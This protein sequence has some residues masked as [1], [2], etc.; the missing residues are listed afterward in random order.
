MAISAKVPCVLGLAGNLVPHSVGRSGTAS[1]SGKTIGLGRTRTRKPRRMSSSI[2]SPTYLHSAAKAIAMRNGLGT[3]GSRITHQSAHLVGSGTTIGHPRGIAGRDAIGTLL[4][5]THQAA[6]RVIPGTAIDRPRGI[7]GYDAIGTAKKDTHRTHQTTGIVNS[8]TAIDRPHGI[9]GYD[10]VGT[11]KHCTHQTADMV[12]LGTAID[13]P[14]GITGCD[15]ATTKHRTHQTA[16][17]APSYGTAIDGA[18]CG[19]TGYD[20]ACVLAYQ[21]TYKLIPTTASVDVGIHYFQ[22]A[23]AGSRGNTPKEPY[24]S[25]AVPAIEVGDAMSIALEDAGKVGCTNKALIGG[26]AGIAVI[27]PPIGSQSA[28]TEPP[29]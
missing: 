27:R 15:G 29:A 21:S 19:G 6:N 2:I 5:K 7:A 20:I 14:R 1:G 25:T 22:V 4:H 10:V 18:A 24:T 3:S 8:R 9:A 12:S 13:R 16:D 28:F 11:T 23:Y 26:T 17:G